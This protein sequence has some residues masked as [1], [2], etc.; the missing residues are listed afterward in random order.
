M[1]HDRTCGAL[2]FVAAERRR[3]IALEQ[4]EAYIPEQS[5]LR[6][7]YGLLL[8]LPSGFV[9]VTKRCIDATKDHA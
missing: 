9:A 5:A 2:G 6:K 7:N 3:P 8:L 4:T 1:D